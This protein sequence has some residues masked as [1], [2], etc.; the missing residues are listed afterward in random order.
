MPPSPVSA[1]RRLTTLVSHRSLLCSQPRCSALTFTVRAA[2][3]QPF[4]EAWSPPLHLA[5]SQARPYLVAQTVLVPAMTA[6]ESEASILRTKPAITLIPPLVASISRFRWRSA[7]GN[8]SSMSA[9][10][11]I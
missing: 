6:L 10:E 3:P 9:K 11:R 5:S 1:R 7:L 4:F 2:A 8:A